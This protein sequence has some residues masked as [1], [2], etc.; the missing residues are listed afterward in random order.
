MDFVTIECADGMAQLGQTVSLYQ[1]LTSEN[2]NINQV[3]FTGS[4]DDLGD[5]PVISDIGHTGE[6]NDVLNAPTRVTQF[7]NDASYTVNGSNVSQFANDKQYTVNGSNVS[8]FANDNQYIVNGSKVSQLVNDKNYTVTGS[9]VGQF[10]NDRNYTV[11]GSNISQFS[12]N[13]NYAQR[14][15]GVSAF[16][17]DSGYITSAQVPPSGSGAYVTAGNFPVNINIPAGSAGGGPV[18]PTNYGYTY[19]NVPTVIV[20]CSGAVQVSSFSVTNTGF[21]YGFTNRGSQAENIS[22]IS[23]VAIGN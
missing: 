20:T 8:Q 2:T 21:R 10:A 16:S 22:K 19:N 15:I 1:N 14:G 18:D 9:N 6:Y 17:N 5:K 13:S 3:A 7:N 11:S 4:Y 12:N 23:W